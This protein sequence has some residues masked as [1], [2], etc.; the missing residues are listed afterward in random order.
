MAKGFILNADLTLTPTFVAR[1]GDSFAHGKTAQ[2]A[3]NDATMKDLECR[4]VEE[5]ADAFLVKYPIGTT[6]LG[7]DLFEGHRMLT[8]SCKQ[9]CEQFVKDKGIDL[10]CGYTLS[11]F[12]AITR[13]AY[14]TE[15]IEAL[16][17]AIG[18]TK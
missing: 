15:A 11:E 10:D 12:I 5:R 9:G 13:D 3:V 6:H 17:K 16:E 1:V 4:P 18:E 2:E 8:G 7:H 14:A